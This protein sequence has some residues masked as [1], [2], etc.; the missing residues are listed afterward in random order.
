MKSNNCSCHIS[1]SECKASCFYL[2]H[3]I[4]GVFTILTAVGLHKHMGICW[5]HPP[6]ASLPWCHK[7]SRRKFAPC[8]LWQSRCLDVSSDTHFVA[9]SRGPQQTLNPPQHTFPLAKGQRQIATCQKSAHSLFTK[10]LWIKNIHWTA[11]TIWDPVYSWS[12]CKRR[13][14]V[15]YICVIMSCIKWKSKSD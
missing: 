5:V 15:Y 9:R 13:L 11:W 10:V 12:I 4:L 1:L 8:G 7:N 3:F 14:N 6:R 2:F